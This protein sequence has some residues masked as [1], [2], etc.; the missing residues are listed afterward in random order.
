MTVEIVLCDLCASVV[1]TV[2]LKTPRAA[3]DRDRAGARYLDKPKRYH[4]RNKRVQLFARAGHLED[5][6]FGRRVDDARP[7][8]VGEPQRRDTCALICSMII[9][10]PLVT[11]VMRDRLLLRSTSA[12]VRL[13][14]L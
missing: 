12:T 5:K 10:V 13:S 4:E 2:I 7:E 9:G 6:A 1:K 11:I 14:I 8:D 3:R